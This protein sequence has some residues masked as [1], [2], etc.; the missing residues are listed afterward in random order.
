MFCA[1]I[2]RAK[3]QIKDAIQDN[4]FLKKLDSAQVREIVDCM[5]QKSVRKDHYIITEGEAGQHVYV[6]AGLFD[7]HLLI[8]LVLQTLLF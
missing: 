4:D 2:H 3:Q 1:Y 5:Y 7:L 6:A 8:N